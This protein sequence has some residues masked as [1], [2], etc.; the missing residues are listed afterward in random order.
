MLLQKKDKKKKIVTKVYRE[1][2]TYC[3]HVVHGLHFR[4]TVLVSPIGPIQFYPKTR[5]RPERE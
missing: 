1:E 4:S 3:V 5:R 2:S